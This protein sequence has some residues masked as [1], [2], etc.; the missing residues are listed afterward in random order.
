VNEI[1]QSRRIP[2][3]E[4]ADRLLAQLAAD[5]DVSLEAIK[6]QRLLTA[7]RDRDYV[8]E[9]CQRVSERAASLS[10]SGK[11]RS[12]LKRHCEASL[13]FQ[14]IFSGLEREGRA[15]SIWKANFRDLA[16][17]AVNA[18]EDIFFH[19]VFAA[20]SQ[21]EKGASFSRFFQAGEAEARL[22]RDY[23]DWTIMILNEAR[24]LANQSGTCNLPREEMYSAFEFAK[25]VERAELIW[26]LY[27]FNEIEAYVKGNEMTFDE[28]PRAREQQRMVNYARTFNS[29]VGENFGY[30]HQFTKARRDYTEKL[31]E[32]D[33]MPLDAFLSS[34][35]GRDLAATLRTPSFE[36]REMLH[37]RL[38]YLIDLD[39]HFKLPSGK[40]SYREL[41]D[42][43]VS[44]HKFSYLLQVWSTQGIPKN[45]AVTPPIVAS[46]LFAGF[47]MTDMGVPQQKARNLMRQF[48]SNAN[49]RIDLF[50]RPLL[51]I[52]SGDLLISS[53]AVQTSRFDRNLVHI[54]TAEISLDVSAKGK[55]PFSILI[56]EL[57]RAGFKHCENVPVMDGTQTRTDIDV[58]AAKDGVLFVL[59]SKVLPQSDNSYEEWKNMQ[60]VFFAAAQM[61]ESLRGLESAVERR[62]AQLGLPK[63]YRVIPILITNVWD[64]TGE[65]IGGFVV[66]DFSYMGNVLSGAEARIK[67]LGEKGIVGAIRFIE[68][69]YPSANELLRLIKK[70]FHATFLT[71][72]AEYRRD[73]I[74]F[75]SKAVTVS[76]RMVE[77]LGFAQG[78]EDNETLDPST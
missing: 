57:D 32:A 11:R 49:A 36:M 6:T 47:L 34:P 68:G 69:Q 74:A 15:L 53:A 1:K 61:N 13:F 9:V 28:L 75:G 46:D 12:V 29:D 16:S 40:F 70:P 24:S 23:T 62:R 4:W 2:A 71:V 42:C 3:Q 26:S 18:L 72:E 35:I 56:K 44:L 22:I 8:A 7:S 25:L 76:V 33:E 19:N 31:S 17:E 78:T 58:M 21:F 54:L 37:A 48:T 67:N 77:R 14:E 10:C 20:R 51:D 30:N 45:G 60:A 39:Q 55:R 41:T 38:D 27:S 5:F 43:W 64:F 50:Y 73:R 66:T 52:G 59:Q 63:S 65:R